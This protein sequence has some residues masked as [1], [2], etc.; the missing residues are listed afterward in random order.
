MQ[1]LKLVPLSMLFLAAACGGSN[2]AAPS[3]ADFQANAMTFDKVGIAQNDSDD[4]EPASAQSPSTALTMDSSASD[5]LTRGGSECHPHLFANT[6]E[7]I[8]RVNFHFFKLVRHIEEVIKTDPA[9]AAGNTRIFENARAGIDRR[10]TIT[11]TT[12]ADGSVTY[13]FKLELAAVA[14]TETF[15]QVMS[16][17]LTHSGPATSE[18]ADAGAAVA[19]ENKGS[20]SFDFDALHSVVA[21]EPARGQLSDAFDNLHDPVLGV[22]RTA[23]ITLTNFIPDDALAVV[24]GPRNG[25]YTWEREPGVGGFFQYQDSLILNCPSNTARAIADI[26]AVARWYK[27]ADGSVHGRSDAQATGGQI[28]AGDKWEGVTCA[29]GP[30]SSSPAEGEWLMK[31][32]DS[33]GASIFVSHVQVG[34]TPCDTIFGAVP[35]ENDSTNDYNFTSAVTFPNEF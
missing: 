10:L 25:A 22:K 1:T 27:A 29:Q 23:T 32:E 15:V 2:G 9:T 17:T 3:T 26:S 14:T 21:S 30:S 12:N 28:P 6:D 20:V 35:D 4:N 13:D 8:S 11:A 16:G 5:A 7:V 33:T 31:E 18:V 34:L 24:H 19:V